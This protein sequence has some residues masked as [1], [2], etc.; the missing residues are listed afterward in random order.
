[1]T[2]PNP[3]IKFQKATLR[4]SQNVLEWLAEPHVQEFWDNSPEHSRDILIFM[5]GR[6]EPSPYWNG[7]FD[8]WIGT[9]D[10]E[11]YCLV[12]TSEVLPDQSDLSDLWKTHLSKTGRTFSIDFMIGNRKFLGKGLGGP[13]LH[14]F[15]RF[16]QENVDPSIDTFLIDPAE[17]NPRAKHVY[18]QGGFTTVATFYRDCGEEKNVKHFLMVKH[19]PEK[20]FIEI[21]GFKFQAHIE[22]QGPTALVI[23]SALYYP[24][25]FSKELCSQFRMVFV[26]WRGF[27]GQEKHHKQLTSFDTLL[28]DIETI[29][30][31]LQIKSC[32]LIGH[33]AHA[34]LALEYAK[35]Y[36]HAVSH[37]VMIGAS[38]NLSQAMHEA[39]SRNW[40][41]S[42]WPERK[43]ANAKR[44]HDLPDEE[45]EKLPPPERFVAWYVRRDPQAWYDFNFDSSKLWEGIL[46]NMPL[47][48]Y[49]YGVALR[50]LDITKGLEAF[51]KPVF[52]AL[53]RYD[54]IV[55][56]PNSWDPF[57]E[58]FKDFTCRV[59][60]RS[61]H[62]PQHEEAHNFNK[63]L[64][65]W[66]KTHQ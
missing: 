37:L 18:E 57:R 49:L 45:L 56:P 14:T 15:T 40:E 5:K 46:P 11:P 1:M 51:N 59:F 34:L 64:I 8:Y 3:S 31:A 52:L 20:K 39:A 2:Q 16:I 29:R 53:G 24:R 66:F 30:N 13:T 61:G 47:F 27:A 60:E 9:I 28:D 33:S 48:D 36:P 32:I 63:E 35:K 6:S 10:D 21:D 7:M 65:A 43:E 58:K 42:V 54:F 26:D 4:Y 62:S 25:S 17:S 50:D 22:G 44:I 41:E 12:M 38:P 19:M 55:A 23:G